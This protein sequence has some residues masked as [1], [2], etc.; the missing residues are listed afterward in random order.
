MDNLY[1]TPSAELLVEEH[2][3]TTFFVT[4]PKKLFVLFFMTL[5]FY[6]IYW[7]YKHWDRQ[8]AAMRPKKISPAAR[9]IFHIFF[10]H[11]LCRLIVA[12]LKAKGLGD[13][14]YSA[15]AWLYIILVFASNGLSR[16]ESMNSVA[17]EIILLIACI[18]LPA[19]PLSIIQE[20]ANLA[21]GDPSGQSNSRFSIANCLCMVP[22]G[23]LWLLIIIGSYL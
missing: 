13:W 1:Q 21:S 5:G 6:A 8:R 15:V 17:L 19:W 4:S 20:K 23:L 9:S 14:K 7:A 22:G 18:I 16:I 10:I 12:Q 3:R 11:S 2:P